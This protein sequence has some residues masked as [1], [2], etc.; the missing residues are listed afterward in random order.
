[1]YAQMN[2]TSSVTDPFSEPLPEEAQARRPHPVR[3][4]LRDVLET[5]I[6]A[7]I[8]FLVIQ[9]MVQNFKVEGSSMEPN[10]HD[11][12]FVLVNK[13][14]Y[15]SISRQ[16]LDRFL[17][18]VDLGPGGDFFLFHQPRRGEI[19]VFHGIQGSDKDLIKRII[20]LPGDV[21]SINQGILFINRQE[22]DE[23]YLQ[24][25]DR[26]DF[27]E[28]TTVP[29]GQYFVMGDNR[30]VSQDSRDWGTINEEQIIGKAWLSYWPPENLGLVTHQGAVVAASGVSDSF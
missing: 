8:L 27:L 1:M 14:V 19:V 15:F 5:V 16:T 24:R 10:V 7:A 6:A 25:L 29:E 4:F 20:G 21:I 13:T 30:P 22:V 9:A 11:D 12:E 3:H 2:D 28:P 26:N 23:V 17:P 18:F